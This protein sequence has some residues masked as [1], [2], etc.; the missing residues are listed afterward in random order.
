M[1]HQHIFLPPCTSFKRSPFEK[2]IPTFFEEVNLHHKLHFYFFF[3]FTFIQILLKSS[4][5]SSFDHISYIIDTQFTSQILHDVFLLRKFIRFPHF[6]PHFPDF[7]GF[8]R[9]FRIFPDLFT[10]FIFLQFSMLSFRL[11]F[12]FKIV[13]GFFPDF[14]WIFPGFPLNLQISNF[15]SYFLEDN[16]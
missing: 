4:Y 10:F 9:I 6:L 2:N 13:F 5:L 11:T 12:F 16:V 15:L 14:S 1:E 3:L 7:S 8:F